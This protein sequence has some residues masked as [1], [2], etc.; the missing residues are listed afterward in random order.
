MSA[1]VQSL[2]IH[3]NHRIGSSGTNLLHASGVSAQQSVF[4]LHFHLIP[5]FDGDG[6]DAWPKLPSAQYDKN[7]LLERLQMED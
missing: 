1:T 2:A 4:H 7:E 5:R 6:L 3:Y